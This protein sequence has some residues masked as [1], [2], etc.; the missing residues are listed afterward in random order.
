MSRLQV[1]NLRLQ[2]KKQLK[3]NKIE[4]IIKIFRY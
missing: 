4:F 2:V 3:V 1:I